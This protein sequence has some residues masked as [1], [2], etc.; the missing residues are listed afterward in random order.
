LHCIDG[1][2]MSNESDEK[3]TLNISFES[4]DFEDKTYGIE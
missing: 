2:D 3:K 4:E 1:A